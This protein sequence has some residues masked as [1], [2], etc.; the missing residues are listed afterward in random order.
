MWDTQ[1][2]PTISEGSEYELDSSD[3]TVDDVPAAVTQWEEEALQQWFDEYEA[4][5]AEGRELEY[6]DEE[7]NWI[8]DM[9]ERFVCNES[10]AVSQESK[11]SARFSGARTPS[12]NAQGCD[13]CG[14]NLCG[15]LTPHNGVPEQRGG[16]ETELLA[17]HD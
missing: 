7:K 12:R 10:S 6:S 2:S 1:V 8:H 9:I 17:Q 16:G 11:D 13:E 3:E 14:K 4:R 5:V 15:T